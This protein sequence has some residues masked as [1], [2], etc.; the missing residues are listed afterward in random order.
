MRVLVFIPTY[1]DSEVLE[2]LCRE[3]ASIGEDVRV[4]VVDDGSAA[5][6][7]QEVVG[8]G[9][10]VFRMP[11]NFG[12]GAC[13]HVAFDH[14]LRAGYDVIVRIDGDGQH[15]VHMIPALLEPIAAGRADLVVGRRTNHGGGAARRLIKWY[16]SAVTRLYTRGA[17]PADVT[18]GFFAASRA[19]VER[20]NRFTLER[21]PEP[22][23]YVVACS[24]G[25][26]TSE[27]PVVQQ[28]RQFGASTLNLIQGARMLYRF[29]MF[30]LG[31]VL[32]IP[33]Q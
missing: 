32:G 10:L 18:S 22:Q 9:G 2:R 30:L 29:H 14:V 23:L 21:Y 24:Q 12:L 7:S 20:I 13:T 6:V 15:P 26:R 4:L 16:F 8:N 3:A 5:S 33:R 1:N 17:A 25:L 11:A 27:V 28:D 31:E 19:A